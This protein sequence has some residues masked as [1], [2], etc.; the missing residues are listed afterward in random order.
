MVRRAA[1]RNDDLP[2]DIEV[3][4]SG[5]PP[6]VDHMDLAIVHL[7]LACQV[8]NGLVDPAIGDFGQ[9]VE[10]IIRDDGP[11]R[12]LGY[13]WATRLSDGSI[14]VVYYMCDDAGLRH[15]AGS[16]LTI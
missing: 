2:V 4:F 6:Q 12:D 7:H 5:L 1:E 3:G 16:V 9:A 8:P 15:I 14:L 13:P 10:F 11:S